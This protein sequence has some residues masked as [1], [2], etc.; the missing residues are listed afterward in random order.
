[1]SNVLEDCGSGYRSSNQLPYFDCVVIQGDNEVHIP[2]PYGHLE[3]MVRAL[4]ANNSG[5]VVKISTI[6]FITI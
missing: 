2:V 5:T 1:M 6:G 4:L 3:N